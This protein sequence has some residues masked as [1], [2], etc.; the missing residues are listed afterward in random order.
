MGTIDFKGWPMEM[1]QYKGW[2]NKGMGQQRVAHDKGC[3]THT[4][5]IF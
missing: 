4:A 3:A 5:T 2:A 1:P